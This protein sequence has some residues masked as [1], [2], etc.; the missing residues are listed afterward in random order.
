MHRNWQ[1]MGDGHTLGEIFVEVE[2]V[3]EGNPA[4]EPEYSGY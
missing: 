1:E 3:E 2:I 4:Y